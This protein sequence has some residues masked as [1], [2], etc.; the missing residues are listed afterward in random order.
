MLINWEQF[1]YISLRLTNCF[2]KFKTPQLLFKGTIAS[3]KTHTK[4]KQGQHT[5]TNTWPLPLPSFIITSSSS[6]FSYSFKPHHVLPQVD[7]GPSSSQA[8]ASPPCTCSYFPTTVLSCMTAPILESPISLFQMANAVL[9]QLT[10]LPTLSS[11]ISH[12]IPYAHLWY[13]PMS[14]VPREL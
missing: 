9:T 11:M 7:R 13:S 14:G 1:L 12:P 4:T 3:P 2:L 6:F 8:L 10:A 5:N